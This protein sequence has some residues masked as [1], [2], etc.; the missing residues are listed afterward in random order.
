ML[1]WRGFT[2]LSWTTEPESYVNGNAEIG[3]NHF[4]PDTLI[5]FLT[6]SHTQTFFWSI[7]NLQGE[8]SEP[9]GRR[10]HTVKKCELNLY[11]I[12]LL[13]LSLAAGQDAVR[14]DPR[15]SPFSFLFHAFAPWM[16]NIATTQGSR[17]TVRCNP[18]LAVP[19]TDSVAKL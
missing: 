19:S 10:D 5:P 18:N 14:D 9:K 17:H 1:S 6:S 13:S 7:L 11:S 8:E 15:P 16:Q 12:T 2:I 3:N 4:L